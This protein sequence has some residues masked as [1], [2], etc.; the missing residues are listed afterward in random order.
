MID[1]LKGTVARN[2]TIALVSCT[3][4]FAPV[5]A[6]VAHAEEQGAAKTSASK[7]QTETN[8]NAGYVA[9]L[10]GLTDAERTEL[11]RLLDK[12]DAFW[13]GFDENLGLTDAEVDRMNELYETSRKAEL[14]EALSS[15]EIAE[16]EALWARLEGMGAD[17]DLTEAE[18]DRLFELE[19]KVYGTDD[20][21]YDY[22]G[23]WV[24]DT[25]TNADY[26]ATLTG[27]TDAERTELAS[28]LD[29]QDAYWQVFETSYG[30]GDAEWDRIA[31]LE[32]KAY[33]AEAAKNLNADEYA[34]LKVL[35]ARLEV[36]DG[37]G[38]LTD[39]EWDRLW[40][41]ESKGY[42]WDMDENT[43]WE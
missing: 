4:G 30:L 24:E 14:E 28:Y 1:Y 34:E 3:I 7:D 18:W 19:D 26:V 8:D 20:C 29:R 40:E 23:A 25:T 9:T 12:Q 27:L 22:E 37:E 5:F 21:D 39:A 32:E 38:D 2:A 16:L 6:V 41:L 13:A 31:E 43:N 36:S 10:T 42:G 35:W 33:R 11:A 15:D 17:G